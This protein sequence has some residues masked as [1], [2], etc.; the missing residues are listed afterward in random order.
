MLSNVSNCRLSIPREVDVLLLNCPQWTVRF[1]PSG[2]LHVHEMLQSKGI[3]TAFL[4]INL[5]S[6]KHPQLFLGNNPLPELEATYL[7][8][9]CDI[10]NTDQW[11]GPEIFKYFESGIKTLADWILQAL[12]KLLG[13]SVNMF[14]RQFS[15]RLAFEIKK[16]VPE[17]PII[18]GGYDCLFPDKLPQYSPA[19]DYYV[20]GEAEEVALQLVSMLLD[21]PDPQKISKIPGVMINEDQWRDTFIPATPPSNLDKVIFPKYGD[22][23]LENYEIED[24]LLMPI[25]RSRGCRWGKCVFCSLPSTYRLRSSENVLSEIRYLHDSKKV[26]RFIFTD[27]DVGSDPQALLHLCDLIE[28]AGLSSKLTLEGQIRVAP[29]INEEFCAR[30]HQA[31]FRYLIFG[32]ESGSNRV[33]RLMKKGS[34]VETATLN[35]KSAYNRFIRVGINIIVGFPGETSEDFFEV[36]KW[37]K[38]MY[39][40]ISYIDSLARLVIIHGSPMCYNPEKFKVTLPSTSAAVDHKWIISDWSSTCFRDNTFENRE[41]KR[42]IIFRFLQLCGVK[43]GLNVHQVDYQ[44]KDQGPNEQILLEGVNKI[45]RPGVLKKIMQKPFD[46]KV[47]FSARFQNLLTR[48]KRKIQ[49][50]FNL[51]FYQDP[52]Y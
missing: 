19:P 41:F 50:E 38:K 9:W 30:L 36:V 17:L 33:L 22:V 10:E 44:F 1:P 31:G 16:Q 2:L 20:V 51:L 25:T 4:D 26:S 8:M 11:T 47:L 40:Y 45:V 42:E 52:Y 7:H 49:K 34:K 37:L 5:H 35:I 24:G 12:P 46:N 3:R 15:C 13:F 21:D 18:F 6:Y 39:S 29:F 27:Q 23:N 14:S 32:V 43:P 28:K 48:I